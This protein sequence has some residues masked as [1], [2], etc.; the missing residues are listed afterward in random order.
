MLSFSQ[1]VRRH[2]VQNWPDPTIGPQGQPGFNLVGIAG[3]DA[4]SPEIMADIHE[5]SHLLP[6]ALGGIRIQES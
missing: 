3:L 1:C 6:S 5:C 4:N 2:G